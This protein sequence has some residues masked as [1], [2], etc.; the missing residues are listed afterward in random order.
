MRLLNITPDDISANEKGEISARQIDTVPGRSQHRWQ[1]Y[2][3]YAELGMVILIVPVMLFL[4]I[5]MSEKFILPG[6]LVFLPIAG[7]LLAGRWEQWKI[8]QEVQRERVRSVR[9]RVS[10]VPALSRPPSK[11][12][13]DG[14]HALEGFKIGDVHFQPSRDVL[15][16]IKYNQPYVVYYLP[17]TKIIL[18]MKHLPDTPELNLQDDATAQTGL[19][20]IKPAYHPDKKADDTS[21]SD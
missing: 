20:N 5:G 13:R 8:Q 21:L 9:G 12:S 6:S 2:I 17:D 16:H 3:D 14:L 1:I 19:D 4:F 10:F 11:P 15:Y 18:S 7:S